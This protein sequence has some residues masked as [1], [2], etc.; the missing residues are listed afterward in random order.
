MAV[1]PTAATANTFLDTI[2]GTYAKLHIGD[3]GASG[4]ANTA[5]ETTRQL[6][7][8]GTSSGGSVTNDTALTWTSIAGSQ[9]ASHI[10]LWTTIGP[11]DGVCVWTGL[12]TASAYTAGNTFEIA[13]G[14]ATLSLSP[15]A[16]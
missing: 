10:S 9:D 5:T 8:L 13:I 7:S 1:G 16:A 12:I 15:V 14:G 6:M 4:T 3:P 11:S 2:D